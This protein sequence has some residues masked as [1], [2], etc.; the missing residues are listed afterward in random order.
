MLLTAV[1]IDD[2][3]ISRPN[4]SVISHVSSSAFNMGR[5]R[6]VTKNYKLVKLQQECYESTI[7]YHCD[8]TI[9]TTRLL[10]NDNAS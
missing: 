10:L 6:A 3:E 2:N 5:A 7:I 9:V 1:H 8:F 4:D